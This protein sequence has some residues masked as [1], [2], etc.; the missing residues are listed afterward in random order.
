MTDPM[1]NDDFLTAHAALTAELADRGI[2]LP[3]DVT[4]A[5][6]RRILDRLNTTRENTQ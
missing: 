4:A 6:T 1:N 3:R 5:A 2:T